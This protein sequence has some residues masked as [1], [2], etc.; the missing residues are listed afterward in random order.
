[1]EPCPDAEIPA[2]HMQCLACSNGNHHGPYILMLFLP[3][4]NCFW[5]GMPE[6]APSPAWQ[7]AQ[8]AYWHSTVSHAKPDFSKKK[9]QEAR[10]IGLQV[11]CLCRQRQQ[12]R[13]MLEI[14]CARQARH[15]TQPHSISGLLSL[16]RILPA[17]CTASMTRQA[18]SGCM[19]S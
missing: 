5:L 2:Y 15:A 3:A 11:G 1:M 17:V 16:I 14:Q 10:Q 18:F 12:K 4:F 6:T 9:E 13:C 7:S 19:W 8:S